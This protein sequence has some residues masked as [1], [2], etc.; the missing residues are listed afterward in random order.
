MAGGGGGWMNGKL[1]PTIHELREMFRRGPEPKRSLKEA[2]GFATSA[3][4]KFSYALLG[5]VII[6]R[7]CSACGHT[8]DVRWEPSRTQYPWDGEGEDPNAP[9][10]LCR[11]CA[12]LHHEHWDGMWA[13]YYGGLL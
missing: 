1:M 13:E 12:K 7:P 2:F 5:R 3:F 9:E 4:N 8:E 11:P 10:A 6:D